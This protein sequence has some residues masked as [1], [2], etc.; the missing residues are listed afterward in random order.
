[1]KAYLEKY[2]QKNTGYPVL[3]LRRTSIYCLVDM[4]LIIFF[5]LAQKLGFDSVDYGFGTLMGWGFVLMLLVTIPLLVLFIVDLVNYLKL[6]DKA[7]RSKNL[8]TFAL[9]ILSICLL[10]TTLFIVFA[11]SSLFL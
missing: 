7:T 5:I 6:T 4:G 9:A 3:T 2:F 11:F 10:I 8:P 1:M